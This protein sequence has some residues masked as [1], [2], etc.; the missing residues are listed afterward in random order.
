MALR[1]IID[2]ALHIET[3]RNID[4][5]YQGLYF[6]KFNIYMEN[7][8]QVHKKKNIK[9][10]IFPL[11]CFSCCIKQEKAIHLKKNKKLWASI[12]H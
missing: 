7:G 9:L 3:F 4:L 2:I 8:D 10:I 12:S 1:S 11:S 5:Y 6:L